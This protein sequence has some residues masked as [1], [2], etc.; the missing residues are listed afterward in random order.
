MTEFLENKSGNV[1]VV[2]SAWKPT[3]AYPVYVMLS[4]DDDGTVSAVAA[5]LPGAGSC[6]ENEEV[7]LSNLEEAVNAVIASYR[8]ANEEIPWKE[9]RDLPSGGRWVT[10][11]VQDSENLG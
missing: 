5:N 7:A 3:N 8:D 10:I 9:R 11:H 6:G 2:P 1:A 4:T